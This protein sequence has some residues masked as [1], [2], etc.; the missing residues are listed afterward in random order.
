MF[1]QEVFRFE[2]GH[3]THACCGNCLAVN[4]VGDIAGSSDATAPARTL[5]M[6]VTVRLV[7]DQVSGDELRNSAVGITGAV[8]LLFV[9][10][11]LANLLP[12]EWGDTITEYF[13]SNAGQRITEAQQVTDGLGPW[14]GYAVFTVEWLILLVVA[15]VLLER[16]D[17]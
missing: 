14:T 10:P 5:R 17:A 4:I 12:G 8:A 1:G 7:G 2:S 9:F 13:T 11:L 16:R 3:A 6:P 15:A